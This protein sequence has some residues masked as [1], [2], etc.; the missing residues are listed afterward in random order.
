MENSN[1][2]EIIVRDLTQNPIPREAIEG[3]VSYFK[4]KIQKVA[5]SKKSTEEKANNINSI[6]NDIVIEILKIRKEILD[7]KTKAIIEESVYKLYN[8]FQKRD[9][10]R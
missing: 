9:V 8:E 2:Y 6:I 4:L 7:I 10:E 5:V 3:L 1:C